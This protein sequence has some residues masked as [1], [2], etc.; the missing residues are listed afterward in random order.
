MRLPDWYLLFSFL[1][2][3]AM[4][5]P[6]FLKQIRTYVKAGDYIVVGNEG[7]G[8]SKDQHG[9]IVSQDKIAAE[10]AGWRFISEVAFSFG[11]R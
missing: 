5:K 9:G 8:E 3:M 11:A 10:A 6:D 7:D 1:G 2:P 4:T